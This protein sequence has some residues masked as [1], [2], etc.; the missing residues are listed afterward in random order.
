MTVQISSATPDL[1]LTYSVEL[2]VLNKHQF[3]VAELIWT[4]TS[5]SCIFYIKSGQIIGPTK[6]L[7]IMC[8]RDTESVKVAP[9]SVLSNRGRGISKV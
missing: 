8:I 5:I 7:H 4:V 2:A 3:Q 6:G 1:L 9:E